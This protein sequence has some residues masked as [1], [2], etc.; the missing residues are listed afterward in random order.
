MKKANILKS[1]A[2]FDRIIK[3]KNSV[4]NNFYIIN[5]ENNND[6]VPKFGITF[7]KNLCNAVMRNKLKRQI[8]SIIDTNKNIYQNNKNYIIIIRQG[9]LSKKYEE[10]EKE[11]IILFTKVKEKNNE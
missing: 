5:F 10:L 8:K 4:V 2:D 6:D 7:K 9:S 11:L 1:S 3:K